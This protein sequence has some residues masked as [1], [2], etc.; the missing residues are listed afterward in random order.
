VSA[1]RDN[2]LGWALTLI[3][4]LLHEYGG[5]NFM[6]ALHLH[7]ARAFALYAAICARY[8][9]APA[10]PTYEEAALLARLGRPRNRKPQPGTDPAWQA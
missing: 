4:T 6:D 8:D 9:Q 2:G 7:L 1:G 10:G 3:D 5:L